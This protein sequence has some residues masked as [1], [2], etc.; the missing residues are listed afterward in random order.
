[1]DC[2]QKNKNTCYG[3][4]K[5]VSQV[6]ARSS[7]TPDM[8]NAQSLGFPDG[9][10]SQEEKRLAADNEFKIPA[11]IHR[12]LL[13]SSN[14]S[15]KAL[16]S[17]SL[18]PMLEKSTNHQCTDYF[19]AN[20]PVSI[21]PPVLM[22]MQHLPMPERSTVKELVEIGAQAWLNGAKSVH[23]AHL[24]DD[25]KTTTDLPLWTIT[26]WNRVLDTR[27]VRS[28]W[29][30]CVDWV[31]VQLHQKKSE[32]RRMLAKQAM[33][34]IAAL[35]W[36]VEKPRGLSDNEPIHSLWRYLGPNWLSGS[37]QNDLLEL[38]R[39]QL[40]GQPDVARKYRVENTDTAEKLLSVYRSRQQIHYAEERSLEWLRTLAKDLIQ[41][42]A[43]LIMV[44][45]LTNIT[46]SPHWV[47]LA[48]SVD[49]YTLLFGDSLGNG[50]PEEL[51]KAYTWWMAQHKITK[52]ESPTSKK[53][54]ADTP[55]TVNPMSIGRQIDGHAC[56]VLA[57]NAL[58][59]LIEPNRIP[60]NSGSTGDVIK[61]RLQLFNNLSSNIIRRVSVNIIIK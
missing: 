1:M 26:F 31:M 27:E 21:T 46:G 55:I 8:S 18:P 37:N 57:N 48:L 7:P 2:R 9:S 42:A 24:G 33:L 20:P 56:G 40:A 34:Y 47:P 13:P 35:P 10:V 11:S 22:R 32:E 44:Q 16:A 6:T 53:F 28:K 12:S 59:H 17:F 54:E 25:S 3:V 19:T 43:T 52:P 60:L 23:Y 49:K 36:D 5:I 41:N 15:L 58:H 51:R 45:N 30:K 39:H 38:L 61:E 29:V 50:I 14:I 4:L